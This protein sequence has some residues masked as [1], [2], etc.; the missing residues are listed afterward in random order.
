MTSLKSPPAG[1]RAVERDE[2]T[3]SGAGLPPPCHRWDARDN[4]GG[5]IVRSRGVMRRLAFVAMAAATAGGLG[6]CL[7]L[8]RIAVFPVEL[9]NDTA[10]PVVVR[11]CP[12]FCSSSPLV[13]DLAPGQGT[14]INTALSQHKY[15]AVTTPSG[16]HVGCVDDYFPTYS[17]G[18]EVLVSQAGR[19]PGG[20]GVPWLL[21]VIIALVVGLPLAVF[22]G[23][24]G[25]SAFP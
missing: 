9:Q 14:T 5:T 11:D 22:F 10:N 25:S 24:G 18:A 15:F 8:N 1:R 20:S 6:G 2:V 17:P 7:N 21:I 4:P 16:A 19:C 12:D 13:F 23:R 3:D